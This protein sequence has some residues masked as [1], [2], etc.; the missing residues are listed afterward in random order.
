MWVVKMLRGPETCPECG[1]DP[2][3]DDD[4]FNSGGGWI[5][6]NFVSDGVWTDQLRCPVC[7]KLVA[8]ESREMG[9]SR[10]R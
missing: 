6:D 5:A 3:G 8:E 4:E 10:R 2:T 9:R 1:H 7:R